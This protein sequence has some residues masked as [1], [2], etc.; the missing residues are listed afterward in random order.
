MRHQY[1]AVAERPGPNSQGT[2]RILR[3]AQSRSQGLAGA[4]LILIRELVM[5]SPWDPSQAS[6][7]ALPLRSPNFTG[8]WAK[9]PLGLAGPNLSSPESRD[10]PGCSAVSAI[11]VP[12]SI[13]NLSPKD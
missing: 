1:W 7:N 12:I 6:V 2:A 3:Q 10:M 5:K 8:R 13:L 9:S 4:S 11:I